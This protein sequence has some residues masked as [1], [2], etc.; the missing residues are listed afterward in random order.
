MAKFTFESYNDKVQ[1]QLDQAGEAAMEAALLMVEAAVKAGAPVGETGDLRDSIDH[2]IKKT[3]QRITG[4]VGTP[5]TY[6]LYVEFGTGE[7]A[8]NGSGRKGGWSYK[9][10][11]GKWHFTRGMKPQKFMRAGF[12]QNKTKIKEILG[13]EY[14]AR[15][16]GG[17]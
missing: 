4:E 6:G 8:E 14:G 3:S 11:S 10:T 5:L 2:R 12:R 9:D 15:F 17:K 7:L 1:K 13:R 16:K